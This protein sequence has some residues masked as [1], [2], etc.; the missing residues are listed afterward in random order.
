MSSH[1][2][3]TRWGLA[4]SVYVAVIVVSASLLI[5]LFGSVYS[6]ANWQRM[7]S[8]SCPAG[9]SVSYSFSVSH[10]F[11]CTGPSGRATS[12]WWW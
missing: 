11:T 3:T 4:E 2:A 12:K 5:A 10:G 1:A 9:S 8:S 7:T 6:W